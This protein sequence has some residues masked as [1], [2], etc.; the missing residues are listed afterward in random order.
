MAVGDVVSGISETGPSLS[1]QPAASVECVI[2][3]SM[4]YSGYSRISN[5]T[6]SARIVQPTNPAT[7]SSGVLNQKIMINNT[8]Y[9]LLESATAMCYTG[10]QIK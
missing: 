6:L 2:T 5:G 8:N 3:C 9:I 10:I 4:G 1:F 7:A